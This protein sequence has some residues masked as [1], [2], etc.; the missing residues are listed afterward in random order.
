MVHKD[1]QPKDM[2]AISVYASQLSSPWREAD[3][4]IYG[5][6]IKNVREDAKLTLY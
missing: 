1:C 2:T 3:F 6:H 4:L 5:A